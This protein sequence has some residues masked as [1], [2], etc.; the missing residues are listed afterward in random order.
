MKTSL[1]NLSFSTG[2]ASWSHCKHRSGK[3]LAE[4]PMANLKERRG[5]KMKKI[6]VIVMIGGLVL[7]TGTGPVSA[8]SLSED[9]V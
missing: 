6:V 1:G 9:P 2:S 8:L 3:L 4:G 5:G 7:G